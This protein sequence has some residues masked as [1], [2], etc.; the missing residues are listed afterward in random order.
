MLLGAAR[1]GNIS[2]G[3]SAGASCT[4]QSATSPDPARAAPGAAE[5]ASVKDLG[6]AADALRIDGPRRAVAV[7]ARVQRAAR[8]A[9]RPPVQRGALHM[10]CP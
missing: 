2:E 10:Q 9:L 1:A 5:A 3:V 4:L 8:A 6:R 7:A